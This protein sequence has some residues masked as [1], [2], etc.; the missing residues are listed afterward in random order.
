M[1]TPRRAIW[2]RWEPFLSAPF[3][4]LAKRYLKAREK[5]EG[6]DYRGFTEAKRRKM[7]S[8]WKKAVWQWMVWSEYALQVHRRTLFP[9][10]GGAMVICGCC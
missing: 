9:R 7:K 2:N 4:R 1:R 5:V 8:G 10:L 6:G 3:I